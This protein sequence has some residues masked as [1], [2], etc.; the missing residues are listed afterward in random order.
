M[1]FCN[2]GPFRGARLALALVA[3][4]PV[5]AAVTVTLV[6]PPSP[7]GAGQHK[8]FR[9]MVT[10]A[11]AQ[12]SCDWVVLEDG[13]PVGGLGGVVTRERKDGSLE[14]V[15]PVGDQTRT[16]TLRATSQADPGGR[17]EVEFKVLPRILSEPS[18]A[19]A[20]PEVNLPPQLE[21]LCFEYADR[22]RLEQLLRL[23]G[24]PPFPSVGEARPS[25]LF[26][27]DY[28]AMAADAK[29]DYRGLLRANGKKTINPVFGFGCPAI[30]S[31]PRLAAEAR[32]LFFAHAPGR[33]GRDEF[34]WREVEGKGSSLE[35]T[36]MEP[37]Q[38]L[39]LE[40]VWNNGTQSY[41][42]LRPL[43]RGLMTVAGNPEAGPGDQDGRG[44]AARFRAPHGLALM[45]SHDPDTKAENRTDLNRRKCAVADSEAHALRL[46]YGD[47]SIRTFCGKPGEPGFE[48]GPAL[49]AR[50]RR[51]TFLAGSAYRETLLVADSGN[52][53]LRQVG[54]DGRVK[55]LAG[56]G[57][58]GYLDSKSNPL[59]AE[60]NDPRG[61]AIHSD[62]TI[63]VADSGNA[64]IRRIDGGEVTTIAG[65]CNTPGSEDGP[66]DKARFRE[67]RGLTLDSDRGDLYA[68][69]GH[70]IRKIHLNEDGTTIVTTALGSV[71]QPGFTPGEMDGG[72]LLE[73]CLDTPWGI[74]HSGDTLVIADEGNHALR[75]LINMHDG[76]SLVTLAGD[77]QRP[78]LASGLTREMIVRLPATGYGTLVSPRGVA[79]GED[80]K[81]KP[82]ICV[83]S[84]P[85]VMEVSGLTEISD[86]SRLLF[87][88]APLEMTVPE[89][90]KAGE[91]FWVWIDLPPLAA[92]G[93]PYDYLYTV[94]FFEPA[95]SSDT[96]CGPL[97]GRANYADSPCLIGEFGRPGQAKVVLTLVTPDGISRQAR[98]LVTVQ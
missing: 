71:D 53:S 40:T 10:G 38:E 41:R 79:A 65:C 69:D 74:A 15:A 68:A 61:I 22:P 16:F 59:Q 17:A 32:Q 66:G 57:R 37:V 25:G 50:F 98:Q 11:G 12:T 42:S 87:F 7:L 85:C 60:F 91:P 29:S 96:P 39:R 5:F 81:G 70:A 19:W 28:P 3:S 86:A 95:G 46:V 20:Y 26:G 45:T 23:A 93:R 6:P 83:S 8:V 78:A 43:I 1:L 88:D 49:A 34:V 64:V 44:P 18:P 13:L 77:P 48:D 58:A 67:L 54:R 36:A 75:Y 21:A 76:P 56:T 73:P 30:L 24:G 14:F 63:Y 4:L 80:H 72:E 94:E 31:S 62:G 90:V 33:G 35:W 52:H 97:R 84:G 82:S 55:T 9:A 27:C 2:H 92:T 89:R 47:T 51:P